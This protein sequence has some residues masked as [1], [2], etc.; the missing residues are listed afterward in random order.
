MGS[1]AVSMD[2]A[3]DRPIDAG[4]AA[5][6]DHC[7]ACRRYCP[8]G[9]IPDERSPAA[10]KDHLGNDRYV[11]DTGR[12]FPYFTMAARSALA[13]SCGVSTGSPASFHPRQP[14]SSEMACS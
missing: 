11:I 7:L 1:I 3:R 12:C 6:C 4:I 5:F 9:A 2:L 13:Q 10:G 14:P 8:A